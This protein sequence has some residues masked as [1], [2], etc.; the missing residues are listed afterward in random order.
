MDINFAEKTVSKLGSM[1]TGNQ[2]HLRW[3]TVQEHHEPQFK[4]QFSFYLVAWSLGFS[5]VDCSVC[6]D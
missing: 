4:I 3:I 5:K 1:M 2:K 6:V